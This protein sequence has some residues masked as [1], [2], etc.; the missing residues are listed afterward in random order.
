MAHTS[1]TVELVW[2]VLSVTLLVYLLTHLWNFDRFKC[3]R[4][5]EG[6]SGAFKKVMTFSYLFAV[7]L[8]LT[9]SMIMAVL[10]YKAGY[11]F[12]PGHGIIPTPWILW[13]AADQR[14]IFPAQLCFAL[15]WGLEWVSH[16]EELC[17]W[18]FLT[19]ISKVH[20]SWFGSVHSWVWLAGSIC[21][22]V[23]MPCVAIF[24]R[25]DPLKSEAWIVL[26]GGTGST[27]ITLAFFRVLWIFPGFLD[28]IRT[29]GAGQEVVTRLVTFHKLNMIRIAFRLLFTLPLMTLGIDGIR[30]HNPVNESAFWVDL[31]AVSGGIGCIVSSI[32]TLI[33]F[34]PRSM[35]KEAGYD[36]RAR[37]SGMTASAARK[38]EADKSFFSPAGEAANPFATYPGNGEDDPRSHIRTIEYKNST[39]EIEE[40]PSPAGPAEPVRLPLQFQYPP[41]PKKPNKKKRSSAIHP[42]VLNYRSP[43]DVMD[44]QER[45]GNPRYI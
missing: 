30:P 4:I 37:S 12:I 13:S 45:Y 21:G 34:F 19:R 14:W 39:W 25:S 17:F 32:L 29:E 1:P 41:Q 28:K 8:I 26:V 6:N 31:L 33:I 20:M 35:A 9:R 3:I 38:I 42:L 7:P 36:S 16:L 43:I 40:T 22:V 18:L 23:A 15:A 5:W 44:E 10:K 11:S 2:T 24:T 27:L